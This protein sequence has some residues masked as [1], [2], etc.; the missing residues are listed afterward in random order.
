MTAGEVSSAGRSVM[1]RSGGRASSRLLW[2]V[3]PI[4]LGAACAAAWIW[5]IGGDVL[6]TG[7]RRVHPL[8]FATMLAATMWWLV[9][10]FIRWQFLLRRAGVRVPIRESFGIY[11]A[12]LPGTA[13]PAYVGEVLR[14]VLLRRAFGV[15]LGLSTGVLVLERCWDV[16][17]LGA[18]LLVLAGG[19]GD[20]AIG[21][22]AVAVA[23]VVA[24]ALRRLARRARATGVTV[25]RL[26]APTTLLF[27][28]GLSAVAWAGAVVLPWL[29]S[30]GLGEGLGVV[31]EARAFA[32]ATLVGA[33]TLAPAGFGVTGSLLILEM[34]D[35]GLGLGT[36]VVV[37]SLVRLAGTGF[38]LSLGA[39]FLWRR[40][41]G[42]AVVPAAPAADQTAHFD[43]IATVYHDQFAPHVWDLLLERKLRLIEGAL[44]QPPERAGLGL[45]LGCGLGQQTA[46]LARRGYRVIGI[47]PAVQLLA[48]GAGHAT[49]AAADALALP[50]ADGTFDFVY[51][52]GVLHHLAG[53]QG[54]DAAY[55]EVLRVL[56]PG[57]LL[58]IHET[59]PR[60]PLFRFYM[61]YL[62]PMLK[63][64]DEGTE[65]WVEPAR[66]VEIP[67]F[68]VERIEYFTFMP[69]FTPR[70][71]LPLTLRIERGLERSRWR[72]L[73]A[74]YMAVLRR[75]A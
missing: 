67:G 68:R 27:S 18:L 30:V 12:G 33:V 32:S 11:L 73:S 69:D 48:Q 72:T 38:A 70:V 34:R 46:T 58:L 71:L 7:L 75:A 29:A 19:W 17:I 42:G 20:V 51:V 59:N 15:R 24:L 74:H 50:F 61:G 9:V 35:A 5:W 64:I 10:R 31:A 45:D 4:A 47:D 26:E 37:V 63:R 28:A 60:N 21:V 25:E 65:W 52:I 55:R 62:F 40:L 14:G 41:R 2:Y 1:A 36:A 53:R 23:L 39:A 13:T 8:A 43:D 57:G 22:A 16:A 56:R 3:W 66:L 49:L 54:Q 44:P 6:L